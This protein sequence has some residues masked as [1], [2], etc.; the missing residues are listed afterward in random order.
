MSKS[1]EGSNLQRC[2]RKRYIFFVLF[3]PFIQK[4]YVYEFALNLAGVADIMTYDK[5]LR[6][7]ESVWDVP[8]PIDKPSR[9]YFS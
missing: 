9:R 1:V 8:F 5:F 4:L 3:H 6:G 7:T 2:F